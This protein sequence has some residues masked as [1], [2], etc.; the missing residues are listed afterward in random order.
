MKYCP[1]C[2]AQL[3]DEARFCS[4]CGAPQPG[5]ENAPAPA[6]APATQPNP[7]PAPQTNAQ[8]TPAQ[9][10]NHLKETDER[11]RDTVKVIF[12]L[13]LVGLIGLLYLVPF[14][15]CYFAPL[16][17]LTGVN[18]QDY[19]NS[20]IMAWGKSYP[21]NFNNFELAFVIRQWTNGT[22][23]KL[24]PG[25]SLAN[26]AFPAILWIFSWILAGLI[27]LAAMLGTTKGYVL[28]TYEKD[29]QELYKIIKNNTVWIFGPAYALIGLVVA[30][31]TYVNCNNEYK[32]ATKYLF[33]QITGYKPGL[34]ACIVV[35][36]IFVGIMIAGSLVLRN[37]FLKKIKKYYQ[38]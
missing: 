9:R 30:I 19:G 12:I 38:Q 20:L 15:V 35:T 32:D 1:K 22:G 13:K 5:A 28:K 14:M 33:G 21:Y 34:V 18:A 4:K 37:L 11:F 24:T 3:V 25:N 36:V 10:Y 26:N 16:G 8:M 7:A 23:Y 27:P 2:G 29:P 31:G 17:T 6:P